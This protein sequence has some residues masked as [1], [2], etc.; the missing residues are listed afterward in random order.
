MYLNENMYHRNYSISFLVLWKF[1]YNIFDLNFNQY[2]TLKKNCKTMFDNNAAWSIFLISKKN[3]FLFIT[4]TVGLSFVKIISW[5][6]L[7]LWQLFVVST[8]FSNNFSLFSRSL[9]Y[10]L[11]QSTKAN[12]I[13]PSTTKNKLAKIYIPRAVTVPDDGLFAY[14][15]YVYLWSNPFQFP[16]VC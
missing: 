15:L 5:L 6:W 2:S 7:S 1:I 10:L 16:F 3:A 14:N 12:S 13:H 8:Q 4:S 11:R 9:L